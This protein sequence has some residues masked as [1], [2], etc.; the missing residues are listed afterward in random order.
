MRTVSGYPLVRT[1]K[2]VPARSWWE[3][4]AVVALAASCVGCSGDTARAAGPLP[5]E[6]PTPFGV[7]TGVHGLADGRL[8][9]VD[10]RRRAVLLVDWDSAAPV[11][12][13]ARGDG[14]AHYL[15]PMRLFGVRGDTALL[16]DAE[17]GRL[18]PVAQ[19]G[20]V[21]APELD[22]QVHPALWED[23][24]GLRGADSLGSAWLAGPV[25]EERPDGALPRDSTPVLRVDRRTGRADTVAM[26]RL[27]ALDVV[28][29]G[30]GAGSRF[31]FQPWR[32]QDDWAVGPDGRVAVARGDP[33]RMEWFL[34]SGERVQGPIVTYQP[35]PVTAADRER[36]RDGSRE[37]PAVKPA[38]GY[39]GAGQWGAV[40]VDPAGRAWVH[41][42]TAAGEPETRYDIFDE[43]GVHQGQV[44]LGAGVLVRGFDPRWI[45]TVRA[46]PGVG[47]YLGRVPF[48]IDR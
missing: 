5:G 19:S 1:G 27:A 33:Y 25:L 8:L 6:Y 37:W 21:G 26:V 43:Q 24:M 12:V 31:L 46:V 29:A 7:I 38:F 44:T 36:S 45:Y 34:P 10:G 42:L 11:V 9:V 16:E 30:G 41:R 23:L 35:V 17:L 28:P 15:G 40:L 22:R 32:V 20:A 47:E 4:T 2:R 3:W 39:R 18:L 13:G 48:G 14:P